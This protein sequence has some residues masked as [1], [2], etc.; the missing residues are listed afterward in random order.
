MDS[1][2]QKVRTRIMNQLITSLIYE[3]VVQYDVV[4]FKDYNRYTL[5]GTDVS[6]QVDIQAS[7]SFGRLTVVSPVWLRDADGQTE[8]LDYV[9][10]LRTVDFTFEKD[11]AKLEHFIIELLQTELK[12]IQAWRYRMAHPVEKL[13][14]YDDYEAYAMDGHM[15]HPSYKSRLGFSLEDNETYGPDFRPT[16]QLH[17]VAVDKH[18]SLIHI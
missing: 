15:Y 9:T 12:D 17:W 10:L 18:L 14:T 1:I 5:K 6:Y 3:D 16:F 8:T 4:S 2:V 7:L 11:E 13:V